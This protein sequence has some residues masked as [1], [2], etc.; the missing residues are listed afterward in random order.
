MKASIKQFI[1]LAACGAAF[2]SLPCSAFALHEGDIA[3]SVAGGKIV[4][5][6]SSGSTFAVAHA[7]QAWFNDTGSDVNWV[8]EPG[9]DS[10]KGTWTVGTRI[11]LN[12]LDAVRVWNDADLSAISASRILIELGG[13][14]ALS[15]TTAMRAEGF[16][17]AVSAEGAWHK[18]LEFNLVDSAG[19]TSADALPDGI[20]V[21]KLELYSTD[22]SVTKSDPFYLVIRQDENA[23]DLVGTEEEWNA[24]YAYIQSLPVPEPSVASFMV[25]ACGLTA[26]GLRRVKKTNY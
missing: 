19:N 7:F 25:A 20:Y 10:D 9:F 3:L 8:N 4:T 12:F 1:R 17:L 5:C 22:S 24:A 2:V 6:A 23:D 13:E 16:D 15:P 11:G 26:F 14:S 18:H 21:V